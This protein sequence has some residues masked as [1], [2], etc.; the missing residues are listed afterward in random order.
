MSTRSPPPPSNV[1]TPVQ[2]AFAPSPPG[3][4]LVSSSEHDELKGLVEAQQ[5]TIGSLETEKA[6]LAESLEKL[7]GVE[8]G[9]S[10]PTPTLFL[11][12][13]FPSVFGTFEGTIAKYCFFPPILFI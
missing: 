13:H 2:Q 12:L 3:S 6:K 9:K 7:K 10:H 1:N 8:A 4:A 11:N 5:Q